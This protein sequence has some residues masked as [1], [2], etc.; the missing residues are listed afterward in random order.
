MASSCWDPW[1]SSPRRRRG[2]AGRH[3][4]RFFPAIFHVPKESAVSCGIL[5]WLVT[6]MAVTPL[7]LALAHRARLLF[8]PALQGKRASRGQ[9]CLAC[10]NLR[11]AFAKLWIAWHLV[12]GTS[13]GFSEIFDYEV[14]FLWI[15]QRQSGGLRRESKEAD[16]IRRRRECLQWHQALHHLR[17]HRRNS[18]YG[19]Q[20]RTAA[21]ERFDPA[22]KCSTDCSMPVKSACGDFT[23][24]AH[25]ERRRVL[26]Y[27]LVRARAQD[28]RNRRV[29]HGTACASWIR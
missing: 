3:D 21:R 28:K 9:G 29:D 17:A 26:R 12:A 14:S 15:P 27:R 4:Q 22:R 23:A 8:A 16:S 6:F 7:G 13:V 24:R 25:C 11:A 20:R 10:Y 5:L 1:C 19:R 2:L 18:L